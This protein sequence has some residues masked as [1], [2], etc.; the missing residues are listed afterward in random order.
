MRQVYKI[1][2][3][4]YYVEPVIVDDGTPTDCVEE[5]PP[6]GL[7]RPKLI[8]GEWVEGMAP[9]EIDK[10]LNTPIPLSEVELLKKQQTDLVFELMMKGVL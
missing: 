9:E 1:D 4:G 3:E 6:A 5:A 7:F 8:D 2:A 10:L